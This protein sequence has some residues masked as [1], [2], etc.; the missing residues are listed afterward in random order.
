MNAGPIKRVDFTPEFRALVGLL[1]ELLTVLLA[2]HEFEGRDE[3][4]PMTAA[5]WKKMRV[6][7]YDAAADAGM[8]E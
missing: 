5:D 2:E 3:L 7:L 6:T 8:V 1:V 4:V